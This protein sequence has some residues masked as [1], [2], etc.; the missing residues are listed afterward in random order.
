MPSGLL[1]G[2][3]KEIKSDKYNLSYNIVLS[4]NTDFND[5]RIVKVVGKK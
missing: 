3:I 1:I 4:P 5:I 2:Q